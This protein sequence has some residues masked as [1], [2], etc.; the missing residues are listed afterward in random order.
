MGLT[1]RRLVP[2]SALPVMQ[3]PDEIASFGAAEAEPAEVFRVEITIR[4]KSAE[5]F[6]YVLQCLALGAGYLA[7]IPTKKALSDA[8]LAEMTGAEQF[9][10]VLECVA[11]GWGYFTKVPV[12]KAMSDSGLVEMTSA[13]QFWYVLQ[14]LSLGVGYFAKI[15]MKKALKDSGVSKM[16]DAE[17]L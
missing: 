16:K 9:W 7:K 12:K 2:E 5:Q 4:L 17:E 13:E 1:V 15:P 3:T 6:W 14:C 10:Y 8:G 11:F